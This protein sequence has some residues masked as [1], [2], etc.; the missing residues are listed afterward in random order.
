M[1]NERERRF[2]LAAVHDEIAACVADPD[3]PTD[4]WTCI[5]E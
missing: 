4:R 3:L 1:A 5:Q 2:I